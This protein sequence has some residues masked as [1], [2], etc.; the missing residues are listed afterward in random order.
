MPK[1]IKVTDYYINDVG[2]L[3][4]EYIIS[5]LRLGN[6]TNLSIIDISHGAVVKETPEEILKLIAECE[7]N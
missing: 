7:D 1:F 2:Y 5:M 3:N 4:P 6:K